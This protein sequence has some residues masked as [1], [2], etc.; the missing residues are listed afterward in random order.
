MSPIKVTVSTHLSLHQSECS[1]ERATS[2]SALF[3]HLQQTRHTSN[4]TFPCSRAYKSVPRRRTLLMIFFN[5]LV[6]FVLRISCMTD[7][8]RISLHVC[9]GI[10]RLKVFLLRERE[11]ISYLLNTSFI[12]LKNSVFEITNKKKNVE[13]ICA[14]LPGRGK[15][16]FL[17]Q[18]REYR[19]RF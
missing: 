11:I 9:L 3:V 12:T 13:G 6:K 16:G 5:Y 4:N 7:L 8:H 15:H 14:M 10:A 17:T 2:S 1:S 19:V 18:S